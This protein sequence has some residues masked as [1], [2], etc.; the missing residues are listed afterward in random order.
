MQ[1]AAAFSS[2]PNATT[3]PNVRLEANPKGPSL[4]VVQTSSRALVPQPSPCFTTSAPHHKWLARLPC[5]SAQYPPAPSTR[6][7][8]AAIT[9]KSS[10]PWSVARTPSL[11]SL[12]T[13][14][15]IV[16]FRERVRR[17][18]A[19]PD[20][21]LVARARQ[22]PHLRIWWPRMRL[23]RAAMAR[24]AAARAPSV[25]NAVPHAWPPE[26]E[27]GVHRRGLGRAADSLARPSRGG[28]SGKLHTGLGPYVSGA[29][30]HL[31]PSRQS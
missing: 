5:F 12:R 30:H 9:R 27:R 20:V 16:H 1:A 26:A 18:K 19:C 17:S 11:P 14:S 10:Q 22:T 13:S 29:Q 15:S 31:R 8:W 3:Q 4:L 28:T 23:A 7:P 6:S 21:D 25:E 24:R 2:L